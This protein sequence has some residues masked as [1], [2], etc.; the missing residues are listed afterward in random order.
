MGYKKRN[1]ETFIEE[2]NKLHNFKYDYSKVIY[3]NISTKVCIICPEHGE[4]WQTPASHIKGCG[5][6]KCG[7]IEAKKKIKVINN[8]KYNISNFISEAKK[9]HG[10]KYDYSKVN[11]I[12]AVTKVCIV[13]PEHGEF[14]QK[15]NQ[16]INAEN[17]CP[18]CAKNHKLSQDDFIKKAKEKHGDKYDYSKV[19]YINNYTNVCIICPEH[20]EFWQMA[21]EHLKYGCLKCSK[22]LLGKR[23]KKDNKYFIKK[24]KESHGNTYDYSKV[25]YKGNEIPVC[26]ICPEHGEFWQTPHTHYGNHGCPFCTN[27]KNINEHKCF[28]D[29]VKFLPDVKISQQKKFTWLKYKKKMS[30]DIFI[31]PYNIAIEYQGKQHFSPIDF[32]GG[33]E[34][35][36]DCLERDMEKIRLCEKHN[37]KLIHFSYNKNCVPNDFK[38][39]KVITDIEELKTIINN[40][41]NEKK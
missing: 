22:Q 41:I 40:Y 14:W 37:V 28:E 24:A 34:S 15:P 10:E 36:S 3:K 12:N 16:H 18:L 30:L 29:I 8:N 25:N 4:F 11:Y 35:F 27:E 2:S 9:I 31:E 13:C 19:E 23:C 21:K 39:Y 17:G 32:F 33:E 26:I 5:C 38:H 1:K 20:G 6:S 7:Q